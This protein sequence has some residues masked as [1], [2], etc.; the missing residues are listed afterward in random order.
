MAYRVLFDATTLC[1]ATLSPAGIDMALLQLARPR[2]GHALLEAV[3]TTEVVAEWVSNCRRGFMVRGQQV[4]IE[5]DMID[6]F[7]DLLTPLLSQ[8]LVAQV[9]TGRAA[10]P[11][12]PVQHEGG[13]RIVQ[14]PRGFAHAKSRMLDAGTLAL[15]DIFDF[16]VVASALRHRCDFLCTYNSK[17][18]PDGLRIGTRLEIIRPERLHRL[19][20]SGPI[21]DMGEPPS[22]KQR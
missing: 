11:M 17:D 12:Y 15:K 2:G 1:S 3:L 6:A 9:R 13:I 18:L 4:V 8:E 14:V 20:S 10:A 22:R 7:C 16:H 19:L 5:E 21:V